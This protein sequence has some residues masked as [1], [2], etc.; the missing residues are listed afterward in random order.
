MRTFA[1]DMELLKKGGMPVRSPRPPQSAEIPQQKPAPVPVAGFPTQVSMPVMPEAAPE[2]MPVAPAPVPPPFSSMS[3]KT[4][5]DDFSQRIKEKHASP[6]TVLAAEQDAA[7][8]AS[9]LEPQQQQSRGNLPLII[10]GVVLLIAGGVGAYFAY[11]QYAITAQTVILAP[12]VSAPIF[13]DQREQVS[14]L[15]NDLFKT[16]QQSV[17]R[18]IAAGAVRF[19][20]FSPTATAAESV[21]SALRMPVPGALQRNVNPEGSMAGVVNIG[22]IQSPFFILSVLS[23]SD[24][25]SGMLFWE[26][27]LPRDLAPLFSA[28]PV[29]V[30]TLSL[31][32]TTSATS[33][34]KTKAVGKATSTPP[35]PLPKPKLAFVDEVI[36]N[37]DVRVYRDEAGK[38]V[39]LYGYWNQTT[40]IIAR[41]PAAFAEILQRLA[42]S[43]AK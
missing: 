38:S 20:Y 8:G 15:G 2:P 32:T 28:Y 22:G 27:L 19:L 33:T 40:L 7:P 41:D 36:A 30:Q 35:L 10:A 6:A 34:P 18:P 14:G 43:R 17:S 13:V 42:T 25:F 23:Y 24:T 21:F 39:V 29:P 1:S 12:S 5:S 9:R 37:H 11:I 26:P 4:Y 16:I 3:I 31:A